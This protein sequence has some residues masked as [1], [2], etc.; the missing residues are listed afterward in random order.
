MI[1]CNIYESVYLVA[2]FDILKLA[3]PLISLISTNLKIFNSIRVNSKLNELYFTIKKN[4]E[5]KSIS[6]D[7]SHYT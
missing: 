6:I 7:I 1:T 3:F 4:S 5:L 2:H